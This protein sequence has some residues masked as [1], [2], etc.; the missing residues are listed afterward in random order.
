MPTPKKKPVTKKVVKKTTVRGHIQADLLKAIP[1]MSDKAFSN[2][3]DILNG[4]DGIGEDDTYDWAESMSNELQE[5]ENLVREAKRKETS[6]KLDKL[7]ISRMEL[8][9]YLNNG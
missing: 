5:R 8:V 9:D 2:M 3:L 4:I 6:L 7:G 1:L